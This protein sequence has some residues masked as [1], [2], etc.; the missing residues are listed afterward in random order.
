MS[1]LAFLSHTQ[2]SLPLFLAPYPRFTPQSSMWLWLTWEPRASRVVTNCLQYLEDGQGD[3]KARFFFPCTVKE[4]VVHL[5]PWKSVDKSAKRN[6]VALMVST[7]ALPLTSGRLWSHLIPFIWAKCVERYLCS[8]WA[9]CWL[10][11]KLLKKDWYFSLIWQGKIFQRNSLSSCRGLGSSEW[12][13]I[14]E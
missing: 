13:E 14:R 9:I 12:L 8:L 5:S 2:Y 7:A 6:S 4:A 11:F 3:W 10:Y 1:V